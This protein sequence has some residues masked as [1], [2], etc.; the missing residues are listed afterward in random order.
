MGSG[1]GKELHHHPWHFGHRLSPCVAP[2]TLVL[3]YHGLPPQMSP[4]GAFLYS[5]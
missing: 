1:T 2:S 5:C 3:M 4:F